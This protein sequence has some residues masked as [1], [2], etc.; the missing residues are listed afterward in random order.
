M[1]DMMLTGRVLDADEG[2]PWPQPL[3]LRRRCRS[4][5]GHE[6]AFKIAANAPLS[7]Y[8]VV[9]ALPRIADMSQ[10]DGLFVESLMAP[11]RRAT[12]R[13]SSACAPFSK[14]GRHQG[15]EGVTPA[16]PAPQ[17]PALHA[18]VQRVSAA[19]CRCVSNS[20]GWCSGAAFAR[21]LGEVPLRLTD[22]WNTGR[23]WRPS[24]RLSPAARPTAATGAHQ[25][26]QMLQR[27]QAGPGAVEPRAERRASAGDPVRQR[28]RTPEPGAGAMWA[29]CRGA[30]VAGVFA[31]VA[32]PRKLRHILGVT[33][34]GLVFASVPA[35]ARAIEAAVR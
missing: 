35:Y 5:Q 25:L 29:A 15:E 22:A 4:G 7:N 20:A 16:P 1:T 13:P 30:G 33:T 6:L 11:S 21:T 28:P 27:A 12:T 23:L 2:R 17:T 10:S 8:A 19:A 32:G 34:P 3:P 24:A 18:T 14:A 26:A 9:Q 31:A